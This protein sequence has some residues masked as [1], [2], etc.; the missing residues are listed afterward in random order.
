MDID[1]LPED[2]N[3]SITALCLSRIWSLHCKQEIPGQLLDVVCHSLCVY[4]LHVSF[5]SWALKWYLLSVAGY[6]ISGGNVTI[7]VYS[8]GKC[9]WYQATYSSLW[10]RQ[11]KCFSKIWPCWWVIFF[12]QEYMY[13]YIEK[14]MSILYQIFRQCTALGMLPCSFYSYDSVIKIFVAFFFPDPQSRFVIDSTTAEVSV[15][16]KLIEGQSTVV[17]KVTYISLFTRICSHVLMQN[18][19]SQAFPMS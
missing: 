1:G 6:Q 5:C 13:M 9:Y 7:F 17:L 19:N 10:R 3:F 8:V 2:I 12:N 15:N 14:K 11:L 18:G 4:M 16:A